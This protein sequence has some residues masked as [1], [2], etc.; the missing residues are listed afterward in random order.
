[1]L[2]RA[3][4]RA[5]APVLTPYLYAQIAFATLFGWLAFDHI[6]DGFAWLGIGVIAFSG[7]GNAVV[8]SR[9]IAYR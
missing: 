1:M 8:T 2:I 3:Y 6:P 4:S 7:I 5:S 9:E